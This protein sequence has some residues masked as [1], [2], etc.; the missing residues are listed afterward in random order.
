MAKYILTI[1]LLTVTL[2]AQVKFD[3]YFL[4][5]TLRLDY[6]HSG[7]DTEDIYTFDELIEEPY[8]GGSKTNLIDE[9]NLGNLMVKVFDEETGELIYSRG[10]STLFWEWQTTKEAEEYMGTMSESVVFPYPKSKVRV[11]IHDRDEQNGWYKVWEHHVDPTSYFVREQQNL[12]FDNFKVHY[13]GDPAT[14]YDIVFL[15]EGYTEEEMPLFK[16]KVQ[17]F[18]DTL[19]GYIPFGEMKDKINIWGVEAYSE[20][21]GTDIPGDDIWKNTVMNSNF[22]TFDSERY[23]MTEDYKAVRDVASNAPYDQIVILANSP[24]YGGGAIYNF[25][26]LTVANHPVSVMI[27]IHELGHGLAGLADEY[28]GDVSYEEFYPLDVEPWEPNITTL[29]DFD[30]KWKH[31]LDE[32][33]PVPTP[34]TP[35]YE[36]VIGVYEG[37]GYTMEGVYRF[38]QQTIMNSFRENRFYEVSEDAIRRVINFYAE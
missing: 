11:E 34:E 8:W 37:G 12:K 36:N 28:E 4:D 19:F 2:T 30:K 29:V 5:K 7:T 31:M 23:I 1:L 9:L 3:D 17:E 38:R 10:Y 15:P 22:Y 35:E 14:K 21:T 18:T 26:T 20:E 25:Y 13:S 16:Q 32:D 27:F 24:K 6:Y 33:T